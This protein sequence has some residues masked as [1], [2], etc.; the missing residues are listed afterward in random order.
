MPRSYMC[1][2]I[3]LI[4][5]EYYEYGLAQRKS[6]GSVNTDKVYSRYGSS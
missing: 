3:P 5:V 2:H 4:A 1:Y 6:T